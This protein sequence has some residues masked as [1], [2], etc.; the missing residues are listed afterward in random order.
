MTDDE[1][2]EVT[3]RIAKKIFESAKVI[4]IAEF[5]PFMTDQ[6]KIE[7]ALYHAI[8]VGVLEKFT[9]NFMKILFEIAKASGMSADQLKTVINDSFNEL[10]NTIVDQRRFF[11][12]KYYYDKG[13][14]N[15][16]IQ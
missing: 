10:L 11:I 15:E 13:D 16:T 5:E 1:I 8:H 9:A 6:G 7:S 12:K 4:F 3:D 2:D 14:V